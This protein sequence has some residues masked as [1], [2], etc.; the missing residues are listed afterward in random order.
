MDEQA[1]LNNVQPQ[2]ADAGAAYRPLL[3]QET[4]YEGITG[5]LPLDGVAEHYEDPPAY[6]EYAPDHDE[7]GSKSNPQNWN[8]SR[9]HL[10]FFL[11]LSCSL[12]ADSG[13][14]IS[15]SVRKSLATYDLP[16]DQHYKLNVLTPE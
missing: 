12:L 13:L 6:V 10:V 3:E 14:R 2:A 15:D 9:K 7:A 8:P 5:Q 1:P 4:Y 11:V 16:H